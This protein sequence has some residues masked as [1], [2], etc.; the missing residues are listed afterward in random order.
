MKKTLAML[1]VLLLAVGLFAA[2][3]AEPKASE[4]AAEE[5]TAETVAPDESEE[6]E[7]SEAAGDTFTIGYVCNNFNDTFQVYVKDAAKAKAEELGL[8]FKEADSQEDTIKQQ[9]QVKAFIVEGVDA[10][11]VVPVS[12]DATEP[13]TEAAEDAG[14]PLVYVNRNPFGEDVP[15]GSY[16]VGSQEIIAGQMQAD[17]IGE[18]LGGEGKV[19]IL[20]GKLDNEGAIKRTEGNTSTFEEKY[21]GIEVLGIEVGDWQRDQG[22]EITENWLT[23]YGNDIDAI[24]ANN[25]EM[26][27]GALQCLVNAGRDDVLVVG[28]DFIPDAKAS[29]QQEGGMD[30]SVLQDAVGQGEGAVNVVNDVLT[31]GSAEKLTWIPFVLIT[32]ENV[33]QY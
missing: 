24:L 22:L 17:F 31:K 18:Q 28:V 13:I 9:D 7:T 6:A 11:I 29:I 2:C 30:A 19:C 14:I 23:A 1:L 27:L 32:P 26:A 5:S 16:Y 3:S 4:S 33:D 12:T 10:L 20:E 25:D 8:V 15:D 21:P